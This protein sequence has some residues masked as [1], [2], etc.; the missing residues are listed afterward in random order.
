MILIK[1]TS[2]ARQWIRG[3]ALVAGALA[4]ASCIAADTDDTTNSRLIQSQQPNSR[5]PVQAGDIVIA[6]QDFAHAIRELPEVANAEKPPL[7]QFTGI[8]SI[9]GPVPVDTDDYTNLL[10]DRLVVGT[11]QKLRFVERE[12]PPLVTPKSKKIKSHK[13]LPPPVDANSDPDYQVLAEL[14]GKSDGDLYRIQIQFVDFH[15]GAILYDGLYSIRKEA[16]GANPEGNGTG[17][18]TQPPPAAT[19]PPPSAETGVSTPP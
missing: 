2:E 13:D 17:D 1:M 14:R 15:S 19:T 4:L 3:G 10:R 18:N 16:V 6:G 9:V 8:T 12:L 11:Y 7:V 5:V